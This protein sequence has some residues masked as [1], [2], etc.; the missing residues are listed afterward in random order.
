VGLELI[1]AII[2]ISLILIN[3][4]LF[5]IPGTTVFGIAGA[6]GLIAGLVLAFNYG[7]VVGTWTL[8][9]SLLMLLLSFWLFIRMLRNRKLAVQAEISGRVNVIAEEVQVNIGD[10][11]E[12]ISVLRPNGKVLIGNQK[13]EAYSFGSYIDKGTKV[14]IAKITAD[15][16]YVKP[17]STN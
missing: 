16:I 9:G 3:V 15:K 12:T 14:V 10:E 6:A 1:I 5:I 2:I 8:V 4:E 13:F 11:G 7:P 17:S